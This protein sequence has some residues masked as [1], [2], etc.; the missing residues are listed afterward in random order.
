M[1]ID[2]RFLAELILDKLVK[3]RIDLT[4]EFNKPG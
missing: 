3:E 1:K 4:K 2:R